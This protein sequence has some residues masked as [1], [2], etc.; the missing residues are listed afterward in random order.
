MYSRAHGWPVSNHNTDAPSGASSATIDDVV[1]V[2]RHGAKV[3]LSAVARQRDLGLRAA[4]DGAGNVIALSGISLD[5]TASKQNE[6]TLRLTLEAA[7]KQQV[8]L[9]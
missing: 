9:G 7:L 2:A 5:L 8:R 4:S 6:E 1:A 3:G